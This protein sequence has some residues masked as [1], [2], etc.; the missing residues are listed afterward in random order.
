MP[1]VR[2]LLTAFSS[3]ELSPLMFGRVNTDQYR[4]GCKEL[5]NM[6]PDRRGGAYTRPAFRFAGVPKE[7][8]T[9]RLVPFIVSRETSYAKE[10]GNNYMRFWNNGGQVM[11]SGSPVEIPTD[12]VSAEL[13]D[14][15]YV[16]A[17]DI[18]YLVT[19]AK[20]PRRLA[21]SSDTVWDLTVP[22]FN[23]AV[24]DANSDGDVSGFPRTVAFFQQRLF[25]GGRASEPQTLWSSRAGDFEEFTP[26]GGVSVADDPLILPIAA[27]TKETIQWLSSSRTLYVGTT[28]N[29]HTMLVNGFL[30]PDNP[31]QI[32]RQSDYGSRYI[33]PVFVGSQTMFVESS[34]NRLRNFDLNLRAN[35]ELYDSVDLSLL[36]E[37]LVSEGISQIVYQQIPES[38]VWCVTDSGKLLSMTYDPSL[39]GTGYEGIGWAEHPIDGIVES[40]TVIPTPTRDD[41]WA[42]I[43]RNGTR[44]IAY[45]DDS[46]YCLDASVVKEDVTPFTVVDGLDHLEGEEVSIVADGYLVPDQVVTGGEITLDIPARFAQVGIPYTQILETMPIDA[47]ASDGTSLGRSKNYNEIFVKFY[48]SLPPLINGKRP[49][50]RSSD[51]PMGNRESL[52][53][54]DLKVSNLGQ[55]IE[56]TV[57]VEQDLPFRQNI[58]AIHGTLTVGTE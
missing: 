25:F 2:P 41:L 16:Q 15:Q 29:E 55:G 7:E 21:R 38:V 39:G 14:I 34:G 53:T 3:G 8:S 54:G 5:K 26:I 30:A 37:H 10:L 40:L 35:V 22:S 19:D 56:S 32:S 23:G 33:R 13:F 51:T 31:P 18:M 6:L 45:S 58:L 44:Y 4:S 1:R 9:T 11:D 50:D 36:S 24:W 43:N 27:Y 20:K 12:F 52:F 42:V 28:A 57:R 48:N 47:G 17:N 49:P 46:N